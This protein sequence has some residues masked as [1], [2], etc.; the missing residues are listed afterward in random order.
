MSD[1]ID[2]YHAKYEEYE[3]AHENLENIKKTVGEVSNYLRSGRPFSFGGRLPTAWLDAPHVHP[4]NW[5]SSEQID[6]A[7]LA[8]YNAYSAVKD[9]WKRI[10]VEE[11]V[12][13]NRPPGV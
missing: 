7:V 13:F 10:P 4:R 2:D 11:R 12:A 8:R 6:A 1:P 3:Q 5:P 9:A